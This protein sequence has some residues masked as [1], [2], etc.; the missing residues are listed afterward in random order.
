MNI[1]AFLWKNQIYGS[2][3]Q[4]LV[5]S[6]N[7]LSLYLLVVVKKKKKKKGEGE[8]KAENDTQIYIYIFGNKKWVQDLCIEN[9]YNLNTNQTSPKY[10]QSNSN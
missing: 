8:D 10:L 5:T 9:E 4:W 3:Y 6:K 1:V 7:T 2:Y